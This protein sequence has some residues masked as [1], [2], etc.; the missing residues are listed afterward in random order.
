MR[1]IITILTTLPFFVFGQTQVGGGI[2]T[3]TTWTLDESPYQVVSDVVIFPDQSLTIEPG[4][5]VYFNAGTQLENRDGDLIA[6]GQSDAPILFTATE[7]GALWKGIVN[8]NLEADV[9]VFDFAHFIIEYAE[10]GIDFGA[11]YAYQTVTNGTF[12]YNQRGVYDGGQGYHWIQLYD[13]TFIENGVGMEGRMSVWNSTFEGNDTGFGNPY[14]FQNSEEG[15][16]VINCTFLNN[17]IAVGTIG[18][19]ITFSVIQNCVFDGNDK[20]VYNYW[21]EV[22]SCSVLNSN[23]LGVFLQK[24]FVKKS[25]FSGNEIGIDLSLYPSSLQVLDNEIILNEIGLRLNGPGALVK[26]NTICSN[27]DYNVLSTSN[28]FMSVS[29]NCWCS[30]DNDFI[31]AGIFDAYADVA[32]GIVQFEPI[33][34]NCLEAVYPGDVNRDGTANG[35]DLLY[36]GMKLGEVGLARDNASTDW[37]AQFGSD[38]DNTFSNGLNTKFADTNGDG[39]VTEAD[40]EVVGMNYGLSHGNMAFEPLPFASTDAIDLNIEVASFDGY[41]LELVWSNSNV[42]ND[43]MGLSFELVSNTAVFDNANFSW[44]F[45]DSWWTSGQD[46]FLQTIEL[47][48][49][50]GID[51]SAI[52]ISGQSNSGSG[53]WFSLLITL[54]DYTPSL[55]LDFNNLIVVNQAGFV[56]PTNVEPISVEAVSTQDLNP[57]QSS[58]F[59]NPAE[60]RI[61]IKTTIENTYDQ[62][63]LIDVQGSVVVENAFE[64]VVSLEGLSR[65]VYWLILEG[66][67]GVEIHQVIKVD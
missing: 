13:C 6:V 45:E 19:I 42:L 10:T 49:A 27:T 58:V 67:Q 23:E 26:Y 5:V 63:K 51:C 46:V 55:E 25:L 54:D 52:D 1:L 14:S 7:G 41:E 47:D 20:G 21:A 18:Q 24:G 28:S 43:V 8:T 16:R 12:R 29:E 31:Q 50:S 39:V 62:L 60:D 35:R 59:P 48:D 22:D 56:L 65:G 32:L 3:P 38:W 44:G 9:L 61:Y 36:V 37:S 4:V 11:E 33:S 34:L 40:L 66:S 53:E 30:S 64:S 17:G 15:G 2:F 57:K